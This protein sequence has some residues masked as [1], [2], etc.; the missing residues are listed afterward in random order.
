MENKQECVRCGLLKSTVES[1]KS[2]NEW[3]TCYEDNEHFYL[4]PSMQV[5]DG[6]VE[7]LEGEEI[8]KN[9][10]VNPSKSTSLEGSAQVTAQD[11]AQV[12]E[13][14]IL[15]VCNCGDDALVEHCS[16]P[17]CVECHKAAYEQ[18]RKDEREALQKKVEKMK[19]KSNLKLKGQ[20]YGYN[21]ALDEILSL[22]TPTKQDSGEEKV[23][24]KTSDRYYFP[25]DCKNCRNLKD[26]LIL[27]FN[28]NDECALCGRKMRE[29]D[30]E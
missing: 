13:D 1:M 19:I 6:L 3:K 25:P 5:D 14:L 26:G 18:G 17:N 15:H 16:E 8:S 9:A 11:G 10:S 28:E 29:Q 27:K 7:P 20:P 2:S 30:K 23:I 4:Q 22:L 12:E 24:L 21:Q